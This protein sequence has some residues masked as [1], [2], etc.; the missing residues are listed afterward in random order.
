MIDF[1]LS[2]S[3]FLLSSSSY[4]KIGS[5]NVY[6]SVATATKAASAS[7][8]LIISPPQASLHFLLSP[9]TLIQFYTNRHSNIYTNSHTWWE[10]CGKW[11]KKNLC[12]VN[13]VCFS[14]FYFFKRRFLTLLCFKLSKGTVSSFL[15]L[16]MLYLSLKSMSTLCCHVYHIYKSYIYICIYIA[17]ARKNR[18]LVC[19][20]GWCWII[21]YYA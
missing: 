9:N 11:D 14:I 15:L 12:R 19:M 16:F 10:Y 17:W 13:W 5:V 21:L 1:C 20:L 7:P 3:L 4:K 18:N 2:P 6:K 8:H